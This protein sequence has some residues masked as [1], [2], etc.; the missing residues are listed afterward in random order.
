M[1]LVWATRIALYAQLL[2]GF[3]RF[4][5]PT[6]G[7]TQNLHLL[8]GILIAAL[9]FVA[10]R[11]IPG[12]PTPGPRPA[13]R[14]LS[15]VPLAVGLYFRAAGQVPAVLVILHVLLA[16]ATLAVVEIAAARQRRATLPA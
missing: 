14:F 1:G 13:A 8:F 7:L 2:L 12:L 4:S 10:F 3:D 16:F 6:T 15:L 11:P 5:N 9:A